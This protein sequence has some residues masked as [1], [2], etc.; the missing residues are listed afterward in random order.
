M[1]TFTSPL[2]GSLLVAA[3]QSACACRGDNACRCSRCRR[4]R[5][6]CRRRLCCLGPRCRRAGMYSLHECPGGHSHSELRAQGRARVLCSFQGAAEASAAAPPRSRPATTGPRPA[7]RPRLQR[8]SA[9]MESGP[10]TWRSRPCRPCYHH[11]RGF[12]VPCSPCASGRSWRCRG[13]CSGDPCHRA[14][15]KGK[16]GAAVRLIKEQWLTNPLLFRT[17]CSRCSLTLCRQCPPKALKTR[18]SRP[19][20]SRPLPRRQ[21]MLSHLH[22]FWWRPLG[23]PPPGRW[24]LRQEVAICPHHPSTGGPHHRQLRRSIK[25]DQ[26][27]MAKS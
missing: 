2:A 27:L 13:A 7:T 3:P 19:R 16:G 4:C 24:C 14:G 9:R 20:T 8:C 25:L 18:S 22:C 6:R 15:G 23:R 10:C 26:G 11:W 5:R 12:S 1:S 17:F 21:H